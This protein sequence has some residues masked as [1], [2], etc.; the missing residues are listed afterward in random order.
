MVFNS[1]NIFLENLK[2]TS[3]SLRKNNKICLVAGDLN[4]DILKYEHN[5]IINEFLNLMYS[6]FFQPCILEPTRV[7]LNSRPSLI[8]NI[9]VNTYDKT[10]HSGNSLDKVTDH[11]PNFCIIEDTYKVKKNRK[12][13]IRDMQ[14]FEKD[15]CLKGLEELKNLDLLQYKDCNIMYNKFHEKYLQVIDKNIPYK[16]MSKKRNKT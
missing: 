15:K 14:Q 10:I 2:T 9:Y 8:D 7:V 11:M 3:H 5:P 16:I 12:I 6:N 1:N 13:R 4:Y